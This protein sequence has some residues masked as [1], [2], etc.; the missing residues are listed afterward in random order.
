MIFGMDA[1]WGSDMR[2]AFDSQDDGSRVGD[3]FYLGKIKVPMLTCYHHLICVFFALVKKG[4]SARREVTVREIA[5]LPE[6]SHRPCGDHVGINRG[7]RLDPFGPYF[8]HQIKSLRSMSK[9]CC[10]ALI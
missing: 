6:R 4:N 1:L 9:E 3:T 8:N 5:Q 10:L 7:G 2:K